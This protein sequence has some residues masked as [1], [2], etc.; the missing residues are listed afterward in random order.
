MKRL[1][2]FLFIVL[3][4]VAFLLLTKSNNTLLPQ[5]MQPKPETILKPI[6]I[7]TS[8]P[9]VKPPASY[10]TVTRTTV[11]TGEII[12]HEV[13]EENIILFLSSDGEGYKFTLT[14]TTE[15]ISHFPHVIHKIKSAQSWLSQHQEGGHALISLFNGTVEGVILHPK[16][17]K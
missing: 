3:S 1:L 17:D 10:K 14:P 13:N 6:P 15:I 5:Q 7:Q 16:L 11:I 2:T 9:K 12:S 4:I 8:L